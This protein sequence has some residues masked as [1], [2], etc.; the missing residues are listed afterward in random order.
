VI[1][2]IHNQK[3]YVSI[4]LTFKVF[5]QQ[6][7]FYFPLWMPADWLPAFSTTISQL[8]CLLSVSQKQRALDV[9]FLLTVVINCCCSC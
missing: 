2:S 6:F 1:A 4:Y 9:C 7:T 8:W 3:M 5:T